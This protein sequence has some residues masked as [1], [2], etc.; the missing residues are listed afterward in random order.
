MSAFERGGLAS[1]T[2]AVVISSSTTPEQHVLETCL[3]TAA[4]DAAKQGISSPAIV[5]VGAI[6]GMREQL[7]TNMVGG[8]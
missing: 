1:D 4:A 5:I 6:A 3:G 8:R 7:L 2:P